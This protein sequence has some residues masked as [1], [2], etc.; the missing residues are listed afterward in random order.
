MISF[1]EKVKL[2]IED[3]KAINEALQNNMKEIDILKSK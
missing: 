3:N 2:Q 1:Q